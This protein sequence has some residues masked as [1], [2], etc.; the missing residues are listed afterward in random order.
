MRIC[1]IKGCENKHLAKGLC[2]KHYVKVHNHSLYHVWLNMRTRCNNPNYYAYHRYGGRGIR[3]CKRWN[4]FALFLAD[5]GD[6]P[7]GYT[8][9][10]INNNIGYNPKNCKWAT[11]AEQCMNRGIR[12][13]NRSGYTGVSYAKD[14]NKWRVEY[15]GNR[16]GQFATRREAIKVRQEL[17][18]K[19]SFNEN[20][21]DT[22]TL[23]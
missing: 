1:E 15:R 6:R 12:K 20:M 13:D 21:L 7:E 23:S 18:N 2:S 4:N 17:E 11:M 5:M 8:L 9:E 19:Q 22:I 14:R 16:I 3:V 10:R